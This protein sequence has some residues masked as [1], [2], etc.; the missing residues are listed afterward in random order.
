MAGA[1]ALLPSPPEAQALDY[2][3]A[4]FANQ[5][6]AQEYLLPGDPYRLD[7]DG[8]G[9]ACEDLPCPCS[10]ALPEAP[11]PPPPPPPPEEEARP[12]I[13]TYVACGLSSN[14]RPAHECA[15]RS[16]V[17]AFIRSSQPVTY[18]ICITFPSKRRFCARNQEAEAETLF[19]NKITS[20]AV[21][22]HKVVW[23]VDGRR[24]SWRFWRR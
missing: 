19:V 9:V 7:G 10:Y 18:S 12:R 17:G 14:A 4:D 8:D 21:G 23:F 11:P 15:H 1:V 13:R 24:F 6:E 5:A 3:C 20:S 2:D 16:K 22:W